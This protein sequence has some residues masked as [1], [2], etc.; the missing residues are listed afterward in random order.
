MGV[1]YKNMGFG[2]ISLKI[3]H[4][5]FHLSK[6]NASAMIEEHHVEVAFL[7]SW[8]KITKKPYYIHLI[9]LLENPVFSEDGLKDYLTST[10]F[11][12][13]RHYCLKY[14]HEE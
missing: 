13:I 7:P 11:N 9:D 8:Y 14:I 10:I 1:D 5:L 6:T 3:L 2:L 4:T 12:T